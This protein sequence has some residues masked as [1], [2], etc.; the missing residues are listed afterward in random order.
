MPNVIEIIQNG[1][2]YFFPSGINTNLTGYATEEYVNK[3]I[4]DIDI[5]D[6]EVTTNNIIPYVSPNLWNGEYKVGQL[7]YN[8]GV[9]DETKTDYYYAE[10]EVEPNTD[11]TILTAHKYWF[12][13][14]ADSNFEYKTTNYKKLDTY[15]PYTFNTGNNTYI[16]FQ[17]GNNEVDDAAFKNYHLYRRMWLIKGTEIPY[18]IG[19]YGRNFAEKDLPSHSFYRS[20]ASKLQELTNPFKPTHIVML[21]DS[22]TAGYHS[23]NHA[24]IENCYAKLFGDYLI[25]RFDGKV[26]E[27]P[28]FDERVE[29]YNSS[30]YAGL[31]TGCVFAAT[32]YAKIKFYGSYLSLTTYNGQKPDSTISVYIDGEETAFA[33]YNFLENE[34]TK[35]ETNELTDDYHTAVIRFSTTATMGSIGIKKYVSFSNLAVSGINST[36]VR[37]RFAGGREF[38]NADIIFCMIGTNDRV[39]GNLGLYDYN[40]RQVF[41]HGLEKMGKKVVLMSAT[42]SPRE[43]YPEESETYEGNYLNKMVDVVAWVNLIGGKENEQ[44]IS[45]YNWL[46]DYAEE[47]NIELDTFFNDGL[48]PTEECHALIYKHLVREC[49]FGIEM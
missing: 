40:I 13:L 5:P 45:F 9:I 1:K 27:I 31:E 11:Y 46:I 36:T 47:Q 32:G 30:Y 7:T 15:E 38:D 37:T 16:R 2:S 23:Y 25:E 44:V 8:T 3:A 42:P 41:K 10:M 24:Y 20:V 21:G 34:S 6:V 18:K 49:G 19:A 17:C 35:W 29:A 28:F 26:Y 14:Y 48:H 22:I 33:T 43:K 39:S 4:K 12:V